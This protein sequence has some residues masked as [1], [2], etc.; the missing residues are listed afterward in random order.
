MQAIVLLIGTSGARNARLVSKSW[1]MMMGRAFG[2]G[3]LKLPLPRDKVDARTIKRVQRFFSSLPSVSTAD[4]FFSSGSVDLV[5]ADEGDA[6][7][8]QVRCW[9]A[10]LAHATLA[11]A[12]SMSTTM[13]KLVIHSSDMIPL[14]SYL[15]LSQLRCLDISDS[16]VPHQQLQL[17]PQGLTQLTGLILSMGM[18]GLDTCVEAADIAALSGLSSLQKL[19][20]TRC[21]QAMSTPGR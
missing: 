9:A 13:V 3:R 21:L 12:M 4:L 14:I 16:K 18:R 15:T 10:Q 20:L 11:N 17:I 8:A 19:Q 2:T 6:G 1:A 5:A 7:S